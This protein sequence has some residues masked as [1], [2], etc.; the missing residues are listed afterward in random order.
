MPFFA[1]GQE[2][3]A[4]DSCLLGVLLRPNRQKNQ[5]YSLDRLPAGELD[6]TALVPEVFETAADGAIIS[7]PQ[8]LDCLFPWQVTAQ[9]ETIVWE[10]YNG[11]QQDIDFADDGCWQALAVVDET[12]A[13][14]RSG[15]VYL[16]VPGGLPVVEF[17][18]L[19]REF[20]TRL[21]PE[22]ATYQ[23]R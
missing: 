19:S 9:G 8:A 12:A 7:G 17:M 13:L 10:A 22:Q 2:P 1:F 14:S 23:R 20:W 15:H 16:D 6:I 5:D 21:G 3:V 4:D 11:I 18:A